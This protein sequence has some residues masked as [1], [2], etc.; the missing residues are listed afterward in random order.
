MGPTVN[1]RNGSFLASRLWP[2]SGLSR[3]IAA[4]QTFGTAQKGGKLTLSS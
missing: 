1:F 3:E 4:K 2:G